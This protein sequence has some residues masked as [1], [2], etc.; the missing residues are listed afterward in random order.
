MFKSIDIKN[1]QRHKELSIEFG[2]GVTSIVGPSDTGK[3]ATIRALKWVSLNKPTGDKFIK[4][5]KTKSAVRLV[6][7]GGKV[8]RIKGKGKNTYR[9]NNADFSAFG[10]SV[11]EPIANTLNVAPIN[12]QSQHDAP[13][14]FCE[15]SGEVSRQLNK[16]VNLDI[17][18]VSLSKLASDVRDK[19]A[20][21]N[22]VNKRID[23]L[24]EQKNNLSHIEEMDKEL[25]IVEELSARLLSGERGCTRID[26][27]IK[28]VSQYRSDI[29]RLSESILVGQRAV[30]VGDSWRT[31]QKQ[32][33]VLKTL[34]KQIGDYAKTA[35][36][37]PPSIKYIEKLYPIIDNKEKQKERLE[38][39]ITQYKKT[40]L[41]KDR[42]QKETKQL[43]RNLKAQIGKICPL[44]Q[45]PVK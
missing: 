43:E 15:T 19:K 37:R 30:D 17:I 22:V 5:G 13:F 24:Q 11:P 36:K 1:F 35:K 4:N 9:F 3:S 7:E 38:E 10:D 45:Q 26:E 25:Q 28:K 42:W 27:L 16:I 44:C 6:F 8:T 18:D 12:F 33:T 29:E 32:M 31:S 21:Q 40:Q 20:A 14:W 34:L 2:E 41:D 39:L 23:R